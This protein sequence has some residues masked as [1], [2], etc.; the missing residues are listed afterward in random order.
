MESYQTMLKKIETILKDIED[1]NLDLDK[2]LNKVEVGHEL[3]RTMQE[4]L[5]QTEKKI[6]EVGIDAKEST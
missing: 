4:K 2:L 3:I 5:L 1:P 6:K